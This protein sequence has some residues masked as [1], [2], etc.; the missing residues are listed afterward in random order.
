MTGAATAGDD[1]GYGGGY[2]DS[3]EYDDTQ[4]WQGHQ[5]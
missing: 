1:G 2:D 3:G 5:Q 4:Q